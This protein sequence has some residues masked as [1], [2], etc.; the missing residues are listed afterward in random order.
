MTLR[1]LICGVLAFFWSAASAQVQDAPVSSRIIDHFD[2]KDPKRKQFGAFEFAGGLELSSSNQHLGSI[3]GL[4]IMEQGR[5]VAVA[6]TGFWFEG[7][8]E[9]DAAGRPSGVAQGKIAPVLDVDGA[10]FKNKWSADIEG[11]TIAPD[12]V[13][14]STEMD[15]RVIRFATKKGADQTS[16]MNEPSQRMTGPVPDKNLRVN[17]AFEAIA[18]LPQSNPMAPALLVLAENDASGGGHAPAFVFKDGQLL[19]LVLQQSDGFFI[20]DADFLPDGNLLILERRF[21]IGSGQ[22]MRIRRIEGTRIKPGVVLDG[23]VLL[24]A[25]GRQDIDNMEAL[26]VFTGPDATTRIGVMSDDNHWLMQRT[27]YLE[28]IY[29]P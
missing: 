13:Y 1:F 5:F 7:R 23:D 26:S 17:F 8:I 6:D 19:P 4:R 3:S 12:G 11:V 29:R 22:G 28:F 20:T 21:S 16:V 24:L 9:R 2:L 27:L 15:I 14:A 10:P 18:T 25:D